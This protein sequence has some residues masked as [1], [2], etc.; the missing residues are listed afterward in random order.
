MGGRSSRR[1]PP[2]WAGKRLPLAPGPPIAA[3]TACRPSYHPVLRSEGSFCS[4][5]EGYI[6]I[7]KPAPASAMQFSFGAC[8]LHRIP[9]ALRDLPCKSLL[10]GRPLPRLRVMKIEKGD[11]S[12][13]LDQRHSNDGP[14]VNA[15]PDFGDTGADCAWVGSAVA[16]RERSP[17]PQLRCRSCPAR[18]RHRNSG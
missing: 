2:L 13:A 17:R 11:K 7:R 3:T 10:F 5:G 4:R 18:S 6:V 16:N 9:G 8:A 1:G 14:Q 12:A 15:C